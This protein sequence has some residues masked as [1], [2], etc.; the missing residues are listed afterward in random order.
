[1][2]PPAAPFHRFS[3]GDIAATVV[4]DGPLSIGAPSRVF[5]TVP[6]AE[7]EAMLVSCGL[8][9]GEIVIDQNALVLDSGGKRIVIETGMS[10]VARTP[11]M[12]RLGR[13]MA[14]AGIDPATVD[15]VVVSH[16]HIDHIG[17]I[18]AADGNRNFPNAQIYLHAADL[19]FWLDDARLGTP[20]E[21]SALAARKNLLPNR[22]RIACY[23]DGEEFLP[24][25]QAILAP[26]HTVGHT[27]FMITSGGHSLCHIGDLTHHLI[28]VE[29]PRMEIAF[30]TDP[31]EG[32]RSRLRVFDMLATMR[33]PLMSYHL[34]WPGR[35]HLERRG[36]G[37]RYM[38]DDGAQA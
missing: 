3:I 22:D 28:L 35:G 1:M 20:S 7:I 5:S 11:A 16:P 17:G 18:M 29:R 23:A 31:S 36:E 4:A 19:D 24:G 21:G 27:V 2:A 8:P 15:A 14:A 6:K 10:S 13:N 32:A 12:G 25:V 38:A 34:P 37:F 26:G 30:D 9:T 33:I